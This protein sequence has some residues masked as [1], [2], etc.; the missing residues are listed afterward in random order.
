MEELIIKKIEA[1]IRGIRLGTKS[2]KDVKVQEYLDRLDN[3][4]SVW[5]LELLMSYDK[6]KK[7]YENRKKK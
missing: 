1:G 7:S 6:A 3:M 5:H 4:N 2:P